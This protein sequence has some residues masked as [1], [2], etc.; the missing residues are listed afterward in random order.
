MNQKQHYYLFFS[1]WW[2]DGDPCG[3]KVTLARMLNTRSWITFPCDISNKN[4]INPVGEPARRGER[5]T[6]NCNQ[7][8]GYGSDP[9][10]LACRGAILHFPEQRHHHLWFLRSLPRA[11][12]REDDDRERVTR[13]GFPFLWT[14]F[15]LGSDFLFQ[16]K[17]HFSLRK[18]FTVTGRP[19]TYSN[20]WTE[21]AQR[22][23]KDSEFYS[24]YSE[25]FVI[26]TFYINFNYSSY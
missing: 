19:M 21:N 5:D 14:V 13:F 26:F 25:M 2:S 22:K 3:D 24:L 1:F 16:V 17:Y 8:E 6:G 23:H 9:V 4:P 7:G 20:F 10:N 12:R 15:L 11:R 18:S